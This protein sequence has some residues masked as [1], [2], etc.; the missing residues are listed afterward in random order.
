MADNDLDLIWAYIA[1]HDVDAADTLIDRLRRVASRLVDY[2]N[3]AP[4][5]LAE[6][7]N[8]RGLSAHGY[9]LFY[10]FDDEYVTI[11]RVFSGRQNW[12]AQLGL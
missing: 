4:L 2:P 5:R 8:L 11:A 3:S 10:V 12:Q 9:I 6:A 7:S 1:E